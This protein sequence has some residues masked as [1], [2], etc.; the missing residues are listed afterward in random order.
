MQIAIVIILAFICVVIVISI[1]LQE[2]KSGGG[3]GMIG[4][5][6]QSF[7]GANSS[8]ILSRFTS[9]V[10]TILM[11]GCILFAI[12]ASRFTTET[13]PTDKDIS[14]VEYYNSNITQVKKSDFIKDNTSDAINKPEENSS[15]SK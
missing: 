14:R 3:L 2:D 5:S 7:F 6:S 12:F 11:L 4:G 13:S 10:F 1:L 8:S 9:I 15:S